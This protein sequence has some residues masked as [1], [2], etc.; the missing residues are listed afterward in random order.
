MFLCT[1]HSGCLHYIESG[2]DYCP[3]H[4]REERKKKK[5][6]EKEKHRRERAKKLAEERIERYREAARRKELGRIQTDGS[7]NS[8][9]DSPTDA[10]GLH[11]GSSKRARQK[12]PGSTRIKPRSNKRAAEEREY[13]R[14]REKYLTLH[15]ECEV[16]GGVA[17]T[18]HHKKGRE[19]K[20]LINVMYFLGC[21]MPCHN[22]IELNPI[23]AKEQGYSIN[24][25][26]L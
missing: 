25:L 7:G 17:T 14:R 12:S 22:K 9:E 23:W 24:R 18:I 13:L 20:L 19:G 3:T 15:P 1:H 4:N 8:Q 2:T 5:D 11:E 26:T 21:C 16:C 10:G 6:E